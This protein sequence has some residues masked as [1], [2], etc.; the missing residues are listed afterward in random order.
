MDRAQAKG[1]KPILLEVCVALAFSA[2]ATQP[3]PDAQQSRAQLT[4][5]NQAKIA[6]LEANK[7]AF[8]R[9]ARQTRGYHESLRLMK[10]VEI[11]GLIERLKR[12]EDI[13]QSEIARALLLPLPGWQA[14]YH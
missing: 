14:G 5:R 9:E 10:V 13:P 8:A 12:G 7:Q 11:D 6:E 2:F 1:W 4:E 3:P